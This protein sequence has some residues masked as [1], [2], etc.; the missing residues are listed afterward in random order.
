[1][2]I[3]DEAALLLLAPDVVAIYLSEL[4]PVVAPPTTAA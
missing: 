2:V 3:F 1:M 4:F